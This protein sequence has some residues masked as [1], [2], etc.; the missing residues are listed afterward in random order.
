[1]SSFPGAPRTA[2]GAIVAVDPVSALSRVA[3]FQY[4]PDQVR[5][6]RVWYDE[7]WEQAEPF[8]L[9]GL[10]R[11]RE[12]EYDPHTVYLRMLYELYGAELSEEVKALPVAPGT[13]L[14]LTDPRAEKH[15]SILRC[16][17]HS[18]LS[19]SLSWYGRQPPRMD[20]DQP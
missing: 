11:A 19:S 3:A 16:V 12:V 4:N 13:T 20:S 5:K 7:L 15:T 14:Q 10:Y 18:L 8:D 2:P 17:S 9:A 6:A 1:M